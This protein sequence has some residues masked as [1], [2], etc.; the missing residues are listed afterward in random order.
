M[1]KPL[2]LSILQLQINTH[3]RN[4]HRLNKH[5]VQVLSRITSTLSLIHRMALFR[6]VNMNVAT[7]KKKVICTHQKKLRMLTGIS[8]MSEINNVATNL[9]DY[10]LTQFELSLLNN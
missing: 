5:K 3:R 7:Y 8:T 9:S 2:P 6:T 1:T 4:F 10:K